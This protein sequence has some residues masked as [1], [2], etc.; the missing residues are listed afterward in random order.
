MR[1]VLVRV[2]VAVLFVAPH[3][4]EYRILENGPGW[5]WEV[6]NMA[7][8][9]WLAA[10]LHRKMPA[11]KPPKRSARPKRSGHGDKATSVGGLAILV[12]ARCL[13]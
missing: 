7:G 13:I 3:S 4:I 8:R 2:V 6:Y 10:L 12:E 1:Y 5:Y 11:P 9:S